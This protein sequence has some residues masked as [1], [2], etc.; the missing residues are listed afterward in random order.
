M[1]CVLVGKAHS[2]LCAYFRYPVNGSLEVGT[3]GGSKDICKREGGD[4]RQS[5]CSAVVAGSCSSGGSAVC[6]CF[7]EDRLRHVGCVVENEKEVKELHVSR[8]EDRSSLE[9]ALARA[10]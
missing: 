6:V 5:L 7:Y 9:L 10:L 4:W 8:A 2:V 3:V 1:R